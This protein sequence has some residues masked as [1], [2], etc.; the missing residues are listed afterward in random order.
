MNIRF[1]LLVALL[2]SLMALG[3][4]AMLPAMPEI[5]HALN[6]SNPNRTQLIISVF[7]LGGGLGQIFFGPFS[8][9][10]GRK[11]AIIA[12]LFIFMAGSIISVSAQSLEMMLWGRL[13]QG[14]GVAG[15][16]TASVAMVRD[17]YKGREMARVMSVAMAVFILVPAIAPLLGQA[18]LLAWGWQSVFVTFIAFALVSLVW[19][20]FGQ[21]ETHTKRH[22]FSFGSVWHGAV[23]VLKNRQTMVFTVVAGFTFAALVVYLSSVEQV[24]REIFGAG[25]LFPLY[26][27]IMALSI[28]GAAIINAKWVMKYGMHLLVRR[29]LFIL[30][31][32]SASYAIL[33]VIFPATQ[34]LVLFLI[35][36][37]VAF[38]CIG[39][40]FGNVNALAM[41][42][43]GENAGIASAVIGA[44][45]TMIAV[46]IGV[47]LGQLY[48]GSVLPLI[49]GFAVL[50]VL[51]LTV[52]KLTSKS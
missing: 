13:L 12:G 22:S 24:Y 28:G 46:M 50:G 32:V 26:F 16:R 37:V 27:A 45:S 2:T 39:L 52:M 51:S 1:V 25:K 6:V 47:P 4:D 11:P 19:V 8:D 3:T 7:M 38:F 33:L 40:I 14:I 15:P 34:S 43:M 18:V 29:S 9:F 44:I 31:G 41:E 21:A 36:G 48:N 23:V 35:W 30:A 20:Q 5:G 49:A 42:P 10:L 17:I